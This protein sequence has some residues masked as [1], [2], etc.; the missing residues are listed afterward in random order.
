MFTFDQLLR[1]AS[2]QWVLELAEQATDWTISRK[3]GRTHSGA[4]RLVKR[5]SIGI[6]R[7]PMLATPGAAGQTPRTYA[8]SHQL[9]SRAIKII[10]DR[11][12]TKK[13]S[14]GPVATVGSNSHQHR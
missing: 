11:Y 3:P 14:G 8:S 6:G 5:L 13:N 12:R 10:R 4:D 7:H 2:D 1:G 9:S